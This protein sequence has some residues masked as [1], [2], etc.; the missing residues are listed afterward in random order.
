MRHRLAVLVVFCSC[1]LVPSRAQT[2]TLG[3]NAPQLFN[4]GMNALLGSS[5]SRNDVTALDSFHRS[6][7]LGYAPAQVVLG[8]LYQ[9]GTIVTA[10]PMQAFDWY[11]RAAGQDDPLAE[12]L[13][14]YMIYTGAVPPRDLNE[15]SLWFQKAAAHNDPFGEYLLGRV[16]LDRKDYPGAA[17]W[18]QKAAIQGVPQAQQQLGLLLLQGRGVPEDRFG[19]YVWLLLSSET[20]HRSLNYD[21]QALEA[22]LGSNQVEQAKSKARE[23]EASYNRTVVAHGCTGWDGE[24]LAIP[25]PPPPSIQRF[26]R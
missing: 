14:G 18:L 2:D 5:A 10:E 1:A 9:T 22:D 24:L 16:K 23:L 26:C 6:A 19:A 21:L 25:A 20:S 7:E 12:W 11:K 15:A 4:K 8:Y 13:V 3:L 17:I